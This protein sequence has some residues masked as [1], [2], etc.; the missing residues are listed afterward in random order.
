MV[1]GSFDEGLDIDDLTAWRVG[2]RRGA[3]SLPVF[4]EAFLIS[5]ILIGNGQPVCSSR[6][7]G[8]SL[9]PVPP[10][11]SFRAVSS[12][13]SSLQAAQAHIEGS[14]PLKCRLNPMS[15]SII[16]V[17]ALSPRVDDAG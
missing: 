1:I 8:V 2:K 5:L 9:L 13:S 16:P 14:I 15:P 12:N 6:R 10:A 3:A 17:S 4:A 7:V 11:S